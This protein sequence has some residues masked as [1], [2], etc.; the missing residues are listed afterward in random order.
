MANWIN[1][2]F[3]RLVRADTQRV[4]ERKPRTYR[5]YRLSLQGEAQRDLRLD[6]PIL[7]QCTNQQGADRTA[8][9]AAAFRGRTGEC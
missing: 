4:K 8:P 9:R 6:A 1:A 3:V 2:A 7:S 5:G